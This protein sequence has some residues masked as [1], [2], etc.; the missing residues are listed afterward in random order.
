MG[1]Y[2]YITWPGNRTTPG[3]DLFPGWNSSAHGSQVV[4]GHNGSEWVEVDPK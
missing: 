4:H 1:S 3:P 2:E